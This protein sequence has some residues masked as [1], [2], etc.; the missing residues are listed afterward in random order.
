MIS[1]GL[2]VAQAARAV[3]AEAARG[4]PVVEIIRTTPPGAGARRVVT[5]EGVTGTLGRAE[6]DSAADRAARKLLAGGTSGPDTLTLDPEGLYLSCTRPMPGLLVVGAGHLAQPVH[7][8]A[9]LL[10]WRVTVADDRPDFATAERFPRAAQVTRI[11]LTDPFGLVRPAHRTHVLLVTRG[12]KYDYECLRR[13]LL[14]E[15]VPAPEWIGM[16]GSRR[17]VRATFH[18]LLEDGVP[19]HRLEQVHAPVGL[20]LG[21][22]TPEEIALAVAAQ[23]VLVR[24]GGTGRPLV[25]TERILERFFPTPATHA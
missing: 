25:E 6:L 5:T 19:R 8:L 15:P 23:W 20:D 14:E 2:S 16:I 12:H 21:A 4:R 18:Q 9:A 3:E 10:G 17:R 7:E 24:R 13:L 11:D 1:P 22:E